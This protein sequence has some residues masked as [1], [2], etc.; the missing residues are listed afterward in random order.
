MWQ[1]SLSVR[2]FNTFANVVA[3]IRMNR[4][5]RFYSNVP[6][7]YISQVRLFQK[8]NMTWAILSDGN[9]RE[10]ETEIKRKGET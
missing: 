10:N 9:K 8:V 7:I 1:V 5:I 4:I 2:G 3:I 6:V